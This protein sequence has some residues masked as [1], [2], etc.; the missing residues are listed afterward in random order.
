M[1]V[2]ILPMDKP[3]PVMNSF[4][5]PM[6]AIAQIRGQQIQ[7]QYNPELL[8]ARAKYFSARGDREQAMARLPFGGANLPGVAGQIQGLETV[9]QL[10][11]ENSPQFQNAKQ[12][13]DLEQQSMMSRIGY[14]NALAGSMGVRYLTPTGKSLVEQNN[15]SQ[16]MSPEGNPYA[17]YTTASANPVAAMNAVAGAPSASQS[18]YAPPANEAANQYELLRQK[19]TTDTDTRKRNLFASNIEQTLGMIDPN[20]LTQYAGALGAVKKAGQGVAASFGKENQGYDKYQQS[21]TGARMLATQV[22]QFY[23]DSVQPSVQEKLNNLVNPEFWNSNPKI[24]RQNY[25]QLVNILNKEMQTYRD[26]LQSRA[27]YLGANQRALPLSDSQKQRLDQA[28]AAAGTPQDVVVPKQATNSVSMPSFN[29]KQDFTAWY[30]KQ[31][32][33]MQA[34]IRAQLGG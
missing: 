25:D 8:A 2:T 15:V 14:Q 1:P 12:M 34:Q 18:P 4:L 11:G 5:G 31:P 33:E 28:S 26:A 24:A 20:A 23:G 6:Q 17:N 7:N 19:A 22:R 3:T 9:R 13:F 16:G 10:Y 32:P 21:L 27:P 29:S 30:S